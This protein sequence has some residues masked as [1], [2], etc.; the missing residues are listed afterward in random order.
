VRRCVDVA[1]HVRR[2]EHLG[3]VGVAGEQAD[4]E[5]AA[6]DRLVLSEAAG[7]GGHPSLLNLDPPDHTRLRG[8]VNK[9]FTPSA[10]ERLRPRIQQFVDDTLAPIAE[11]HDGGEVELIDRLAFPRPFQVISDLLDMPMDRADEVRDWS[12]TIT[13]SLEP[14]ASLDELAAAQHAVVR[15]IEHLVPIIEHR[16]THL[17]DD[18][19]SGLIAA[20]EAGDRLDLAELISTI[21][22]LYI[23][24]HETTVNLI[25]NGALALA[26]HPEERTRWRDGGAAL[27]TLAVD[28]LLRFDSPIQHTIR[29]PLEDID[30]GHGV[31]PAHHRVLTI[32]GAANRDPD[33]FDQPD[34]LRLDRPNANRHL[35]FAAG[36]HYCLG[37][38]LARLEAQVALGTM[39]RR[40]AEWEVLDEPRWRDRLTIR[41]VDQLRLRLGTG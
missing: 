22:L 15:L 1:A 17:G 12:Q 3:H 29:V 25:G 6:A 32:L 31:L 27:D 28:E 36:I 2:T 5:W 14:S 37:S 13:L 19:L 30:L 7:R 33:V 18:V 10:I 24:G 8:L 34:T 23:A 11:S 40:F 38:S 20:E 39:V 26:R 35:G 9:A 16:R 41:G 21:V 4:A